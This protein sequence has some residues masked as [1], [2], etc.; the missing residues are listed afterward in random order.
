LFSRIDRLKELLRA[1]IV[2]ILPTI[3]DPGFSGMLTVTG[4]DLSRDMKT[5]HIFYSV[6]GS[7]RERVNCAKALGRA[8]PYVRQKLSKKWTLRILPEII[9]EYDMTPVIASKIDKILDSIRKE[10]G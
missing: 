9:F 3:R 6:M 1:E 10:N 8:T 4:V 5:A 2:R 7:P